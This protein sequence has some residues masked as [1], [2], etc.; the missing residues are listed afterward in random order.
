M[1]KSAE[2]AVTALKAK[3]PLGVDWRRAKE[4]KRDSDGVPKNVF[5]DFYKLKIC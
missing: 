2:D 5:Q 4:G 1:L 3:V